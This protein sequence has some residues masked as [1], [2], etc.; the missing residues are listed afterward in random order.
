VQ[1]AGPVAVVMPLSLTTLTGA[2]PAA[3]RGAD[4]VQQ[5]PPS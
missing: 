2:F 4:Q 1:G 5:T 3:R